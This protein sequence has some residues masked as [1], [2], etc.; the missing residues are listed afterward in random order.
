MS[1]Y[2]NMDKHH[3]KIVTNKEMQNSMIVNS[4][5]LEFTQSSFKLSVDPSV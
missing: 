5:S 4:Q 2:I 3:A 1:E